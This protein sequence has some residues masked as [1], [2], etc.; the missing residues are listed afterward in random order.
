MKLTKVLLGSSLAISAVAIPTA[1]LTS[2]SQGWGKLTPFSIGSSLLDKDD[3]YTNFRTGALSYIDADGGNYLHYLQSNYSVDS[4]KTSYAYSSP[5]KFEDKSK[6]AKDDTWVPGSSGWYTSSDSALVSTAADKYEDG[7]KKKSRTVSCARNA[8]LSSNTDFIG[9]IGQTVSNYINAAVQYQASQISSKSDENIKIAWG[10]QAKGQKFTI[11]HGTKDSKVDS[12]NSKFFEYLFALSN[13]NADKE[14]KALLRT[15]GVAFNFV[16]FP[17]PSYTFD[18]EG[19]TRTGISD[20]FKVLLDGSSENWTPKYYSTKSK[21]LKDSDENEYVTYTYESVPVVLNV[22]SLTQTFVNPSKGNSSFKVA[23]YYSSNEQITKGVGNSWKNT[24]KDF[25]GIDKENSVPHYKSYKLNVAEQNVS[26]TKVSTAGDTR[27]S[28]LKGNQFVALVNYAVNIYSSKPEKNTA[29]I[30]SLGN[31]FPA[32]ILNLYTDVYKEAN[33]DTKVK[34]IDSKKINKI[35]KK[36]LEL[37]QRTAGQGL[38]AQASKLN[39]ESKD[40]LS[41][42]GYMFGSETEGQIDLNTSNFIETRKM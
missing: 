1:T 19:K 30:S 34:I 21:T 37:V 41:F 17:L 4:S 33:S 12:Q 2:C 38:I 9:T 20:E 27:I 42:L 32:Y 11:N 22:R 7:G 18:E 25:T 31:L 3:P 39:D 8:T 10:S 26:L 28:G 36:Y 16:N 40:L 13:L 23:D 29:S 24:F 5:Y 35:S 14:S 6:T 15:T